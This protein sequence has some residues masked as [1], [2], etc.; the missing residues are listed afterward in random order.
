MNQEVNHSSNECKKKSGNMGGSL[1]L[2]N[3]KG[4]SKWQG[5]GLASHLW[6]LGFYLMPSTSIVRIMAISEL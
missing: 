1:C 3:S 6:F 5:E 2:R 4:K